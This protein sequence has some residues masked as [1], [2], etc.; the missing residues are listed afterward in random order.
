MAI[1]INFLRYLKTNKII[2]ITQIQTHLG[3]S[4]DRGTSGNYFTPLSPLTV[5]VIRDYTTHTLL[6][7]S[8]FSRV[9]FCA[10]P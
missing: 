2:N 3:D 6:L 4:L 8:H 9:R 1:I 7:L 10:T 5:C